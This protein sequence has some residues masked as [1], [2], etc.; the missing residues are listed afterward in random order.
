M[1]LWRRLNDIA[2]TKQQQRPRGK[3][4][5]I[6]TYLTEN[7]RETEIKV[8][9]L[10]TT[11]QTLAS[12]GIGVSLINGSIQGTDAL[13]QRIGR[14]FVMT[15]LQ[16]R[17]SVGCYP[18]DLATIATYPQGCN[19]IRVLA[20]YDKQSN[21]TAPLWSDVMNA[22]GNAIAP[23]GN[24]QLASWDRFIILADDQLIITQPGENGATRHHDLRMKL[25][26]RCNN[27]NTG[28]V[29]DINTGG[30][31]LMFADQNSAGNAPTRIVWNTRVMIADS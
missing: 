8:I 14:K 13:S 29:S 2:N 3:S 5:K 1:R 6:P 18:T 30:L 11:G 19:T 4:V 12:N 16:F 27:Q 21:G 20:V 23:F 15:R 31:F 17:Y 25:E 9:D 7:P 28:T 22:F 10:S 24:Q 26:V